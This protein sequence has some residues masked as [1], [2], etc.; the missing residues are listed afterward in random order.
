MCTNP[1]SN[2]NDS[3]SFMLTRLIPLGLLVDMKMPV[4]VPT[5]QKFSISLELALVSQVGW[6]LE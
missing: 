1:I 5:L 2:V 3:Y 4:E 6:W